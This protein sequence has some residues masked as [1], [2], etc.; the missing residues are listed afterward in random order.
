MTATLTIR[1]SDEILAALRS[2]G[3][4]TISLEA[5]AGGGGARRG[6]GSPPREG[7]LAA[8]ILD[9]AQAHGETFGIPDVIREFGIKRGHASMELSKLAGSARPI[10]RTGRGV[11]EY[12]GPAK[13]TRRRK[14]TKKRK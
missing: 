14:T 10:R 6:G 7:S 1:L 2:T 9:W 12:A 8:R 3:T 5:P 4:M 13:P 11:Y